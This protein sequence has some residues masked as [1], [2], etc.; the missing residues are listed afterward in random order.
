[1]RIVLVALLFFG[2]VSVAGCGKA[3][4]PVPV[5]AKG[6]VV[7]AD[8]KPVK[9]MVLSFHPDDEATKSGRMPSLLLPDDGAFVV[10]CLPGRYKVTL[11][12]VPKAAGA[13]TDGP[14][15]TPA[16][17]PSPS[18]LSLDPKSL[19]FA[20]HADVSKTPLSVEVPAGG[21]SDLVLTVK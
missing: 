19:M 18:G 13:A 1:V 8:G 20:R 17:I 2:L 21:A 14:G 4:P 3:P 12:A 10:E 11:G 9:G 6:K 5:P 7:F 16:P 15:T